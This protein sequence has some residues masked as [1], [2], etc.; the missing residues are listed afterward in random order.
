VSGTVYRLSLLLLSLAW[1]PS[2]SCAA[3][4][5]AGAPLISFAEQPVRLLR[6]TGVYV[7]GRGARLQD[8]DIV[9]SAA[10]P[11]QL[12]A[13]AA[14]VALGPDTQVHLRIKANAVDFVLLNGWMK[15][16]SGAV[17]G[18]AGKPVA[19]STGGLHFSA[20]N[21]AVIVHAGPGKTELFVESGEPVVE[22]GQAGQGRQ[23]RLV[24]EQFAGVDRAAQLPMKLL[25]RP[26]RQFLADMPRGFAD[27]L[28][29]LVAAAAL[30]PA[31]PKLEHPAVFAEVAPWLLEEPAL[32]QAIQ[33]RLAPRKPVPA[34]ALQPIPR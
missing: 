13:G 14:T 22:Q 32:R 12:E 11:I 6:G 25:P 28:V 26:S 7:A 23:V 8:G 5:V 17:A 2:S 18:A 10:A 20:A 4:G 34:P 15:I 16:Q 3:P 21:S 29:P 27:R 33:R 19:A 30:A 9:A 31:V 24:R 1:A